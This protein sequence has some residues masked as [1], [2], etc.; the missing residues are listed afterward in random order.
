MWPFLQCA[1]GG[2]LSTPYFI[3]ILLGSLLSQR[4]LQLHP[5]VSALTPLHIHSLRCCKLSVQMGFLFL[6]FSRYVRHWPVWRDFQ[7]G[8]WGKSAVT[9]SNTQWRSAPVPTTKH[10]GPWGE[11]AGVCWARPSSAQCSDRRKTQTYSACWSEESQRHTAVL[12]GIGLVN[13]K[14]EERPLR[15]QHSVKT[16]RLVSLWMFKRSNSTNWLDL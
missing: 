9:D 3:I 14:E 12:R 7:M 5:P 2:W 15:C 4:L 13:L 1:V 6:F 11:D 16:P 10:R 8:R